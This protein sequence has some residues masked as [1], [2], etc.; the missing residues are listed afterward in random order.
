MRAS[1]LEFL[2]QIDGQLA[3]EHVHALAQ[4]FYYRKFSHTYIVSLWDIDLAYD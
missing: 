4:P 3:L 1:A 2:G